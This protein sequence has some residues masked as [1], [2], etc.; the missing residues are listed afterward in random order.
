MVVVVVM[1]VAVVVL[2]GPFS[3]QEDEVTGTVEGGAEEESLVGTPIEVGR[4][5]WWWEDSHCRRARG[6]S[7]RSRQATQRAL[8]PHSRMRLK[9]KTQ[10]KKL[11]LIEIF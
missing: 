6:T 9:V 11:F 10:I 4:V 7:G 2:T 8:K 3:L 1:V 5:W